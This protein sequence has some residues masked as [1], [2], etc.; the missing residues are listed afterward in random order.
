MRD[1]NP[2][3]ITNASNTLRMSSSATSKQLDSVA[4]LLKQTIAPTQLL[5]VIATDFVC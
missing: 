5:Q 2:I 1:T 3:R 4:L